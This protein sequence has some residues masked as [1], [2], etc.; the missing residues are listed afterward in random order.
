[1]GTELTRLTLP[2]NFSLELKPRT[3]EIIPFQPNVD[4]AN[5][6]AGL[7]NGTVREDLR[8]GFFGRDSGEKTSGQAQV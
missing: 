3:E 1:M 4:L 7:L 2:A 6:V 5:A 8:G